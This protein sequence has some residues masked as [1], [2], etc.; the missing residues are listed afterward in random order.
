MALAQNLF[1]SLQDALQNVENQ[2]LQQLQDQ[3]ATIRELQARVEQLEHYDQSL[4]S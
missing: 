2:Y 3:E 4:E 1:S